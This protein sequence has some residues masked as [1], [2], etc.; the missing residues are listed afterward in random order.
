ML[1]K[2]SIS[3]WAAKMA[4][5]TVLFEKSKIKRKRCVKLL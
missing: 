5:E 4:G 1:K 2:G 3:F